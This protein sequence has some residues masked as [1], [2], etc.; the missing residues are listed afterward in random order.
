M[1]VRRSQDSPERSPNLPAWL[2][3]VAGVVVA[4]NVV[5]MVAG[6]IQGGVTLDEPSHVHRLQGFLANG[7]YVADKW[8]VDGKVTQE[9][10]YVY[11]P[12]VALLGHLLG[13]LGGVV[14]F[15]ESAFEG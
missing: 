8:V 9:G 15:L 3:A 4:T 10:G 1:R 14:E 12:A 7:W 6:A 2:L 5:M 13:V 11:A